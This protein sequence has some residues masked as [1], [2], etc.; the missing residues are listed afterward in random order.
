MKH[1]RENGSKVGHVRVTPDMLPRSV[2]RAGRDKQNEVMRKLF[3]R[4]CNL[5]KLPLEM[6]ERQYYIKPGEKR[7]KAAK[8]KKAAARGELKEM[9][10]DYDKERSFDDYNF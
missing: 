2:Q 3:K 4:L 8:L 9:Q 5:N 10:K 7:R 1:C 6:K